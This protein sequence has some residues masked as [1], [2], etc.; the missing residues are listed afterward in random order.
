MIQQ[1][2]NIDTISLQKAINEKF[3]ISD[4]NA[5]KN[6]KDSF[7]YAYELIKIQK[8][9]KQPSHYSLYYEYQK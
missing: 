7:T 1:N 9:I 8:N 3:F 4:A 5:V 6:T 2:K